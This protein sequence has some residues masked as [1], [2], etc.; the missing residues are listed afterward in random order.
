[1]GLFAMGRR[2]FLRV[3]LRWNGA[4]EIMGIRCQKGKYLARLS[5]I[6]GDL[7]GN[8]GIGI[9][10]R[11]IATDTW[12]PPETLPFPFNYLS[13]DIFLSK[14]LDDEALAMMAL[15][16]TMPVKPQRAALVFTDGLM[17]AFSGLQSIQHLA[18]SLLDPDS[19]PQAVLHHL[20]TTS[21]GMGYT[22]KFL[23]F[24]LAKAGI[25][26]A[27][28][29]KS[30]GLR[31]F[32]LEAEDTL[33]GGEAEALRR[34]TDADADVFKWR[35]TVAVADVTMQSN[36]I[37]SALDFFRGH[38]DELADDRETAEETTAMEAVVK[39]QQEEEIAQRDAPEPEEAEQ[40]MITMSMRYRLHCLSRHDCDND[41][42]E[43]FTAQVRRF[44]AEVGTSFVLLG[45]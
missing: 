28:A 7:F 23:N 43:E 19:L 8:V 37:L 29:L 27:A 2:V 31:F 20:G 13:D 44:E 36:S 26:P 3:A 39:A 34:D 12:F 38:P 30:I 9:S 40:C 45:T 4:D 5:H 22:A 42:L 14:Q 18:E 17:E 1:M 21:H 6:A 32:R 41:Y 35:A 33:Q 11:H 10:F 24:V 15:G 25:A 16:M